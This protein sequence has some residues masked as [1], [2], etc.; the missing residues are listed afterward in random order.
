MRVHLLSFFYDL[1]FVYT[2]PGFF[3]FCVEKVLFYYYVPVLLVLLCSC[4]TTMF[5]FYSYYVPVLLLCF[6]LI[7]SSFLSLPKFFGIPSCLGDV[8]K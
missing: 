7:L 3:N 5:L 4:S 2:S 8:T 6:G 1:R